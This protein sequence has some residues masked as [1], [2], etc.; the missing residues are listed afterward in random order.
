MSHTPGPW[1]VDSDDPSDVVETV[2]GGMLLARAY[3]IGEDK[4]D[5]ERARRANARLIAAAPELLEAL[6]AVRS[7]WLKGVA[8]YD[9]DVERK[10]DQ[11]I[12]KTEQRP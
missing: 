4:T 5:W 3:Q 1:A 6:K 9:V 10:I 12:A 8:L 2:R 11:A 7:A